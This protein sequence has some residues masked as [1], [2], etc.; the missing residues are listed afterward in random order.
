MNW[1]IILCLII[2]IIY[3]GIGFLIAYNF[4]KH[5][6]IWDKVFDFSNILDNFQCPNHTLFLI[7]GIIPC[8]I[9]NIINPKNCSL[10]IEEIEC[11]YLYKKQCTI[12]GDV[13]KLFARVDKT[14]L[15]SKEFTRKY[16]MLLWLLQGS[17]EN[18]KMIADEGNIVYMRLMETYNL[19]FPDIDGKGTV[20][21]GMVIEIENINY[22]EENIFILGEL[23]T[24]LQNNLSVICNF[25]SHYLMSLFINILY[26][27]IELSLQQHQLKYN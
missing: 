8:F 20:E 13:Y 27:S 5:R 26:F 18:Y 10:C 17:I 11:C 15:S 9:P 24:Y 25:K 19:Q 3:S 12:L 2:F 21:D 7:P 6:N 22:V 1:I 14:V 23:I 4:I 16:E